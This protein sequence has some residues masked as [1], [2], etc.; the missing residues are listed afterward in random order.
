MGKYI[1]WRRLAAGA[2]IVAAVLL[3]FFA[4]G[5]DGTDDQEI[6]AAVLLDTPAAGGNSSVGVA[7]GKLAP[8]FEISTPDGGRV[9]LSD[10]RGRAV[11]IN[12]WASWCGSCLSEM[13]VIKALQQ[14]RGQDAFSVLAVN[15]G[16]SPVEAQEFID[17]LQAPFIYGLDVD[18][19]VT[20]AYGVYGLPLSAFV[21]SAGVI[22]AVYRG[23]ADRALL[24]RFVNSAIASSPPGEIPVVFRIISTIPR[25]RVL[26]VETTRGAVVFTSR[27]LRCDASYCAEPVLEELKQRPG[28][29][30]VAAKGKDGDVQV[31]VRF[32][33]T[34]AE[35][36]VSA[37]KALL[38][39]RPDALYEGPLE[40]R[41]RKG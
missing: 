26:N 29:T 34:T 16:E 36:L 40:V 25:E 9:R 37:L 38:E 30:S 18:M 17:F 8:D 33:G 15:A 14:E 3:P 5:L 2:A 1:N 10:L 39:A 13:P 7:P 22:Q 24:E 41:Y 35:E 20:D 11:L 32:N 28:V 31:T 21:D 6:A 12:F 19:R 23:H 4:F 27:S